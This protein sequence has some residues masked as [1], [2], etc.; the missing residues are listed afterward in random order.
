MFQLVSVP[1]GYVVNHFSQNLIEET[2]AVFKEENGIE[3]SAETAN[4]YLENLSGLFLVFADNRTS[5]GPT[6]AGE[7]LREFPS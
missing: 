5:T 3:I 1:E 6:G 7:V 2:I 4:E